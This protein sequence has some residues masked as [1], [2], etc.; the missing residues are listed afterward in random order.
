MDSHTWNLIKAARRIASHD[1]LLAYELER[2][3]RRLCAV[4]NPGARGLESEISSMVTVLKSLRGELKGALDKLEEEEWD[5]D[6]DEFAKFF[7]DQASAEEEELRRLLKRVRAASSVVAGP[8]DWLKSL[9]KGKKKDPEDGGSG[10]TYQMDDASMDEFV[11]GKRDW[12]DPGHYV[13]EEKKQNEDFFG[14]VKKAL[15]DMESVRKKPSK[16]SIQSLIGFID[17]LVKS[18]DALVGGVRE[19]LRDPAP[20]KADLTDTDLG[21]KHRKQPSKSKMLEGDALAQAVDYYTDL[22]REKIGDD[23]ATVKGLKE[24][25]KAVGL[26]EDERVELAS[27]RAASL[28]RIAHAHPA[29]RPALL[30]VIRSAVKV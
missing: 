12:A 30:P 4:I 10:A 25:F 29:L 3:T 9:F 18:A 22:L 23:A 21:D 6:A 16:G 2:G 19:H 20:G 27:V 17:R 7:D 24:F 26:G 1:P 5:P 28:V 13:G 11:E 8:K 14:G 15:T